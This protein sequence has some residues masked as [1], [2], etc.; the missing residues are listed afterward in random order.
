MYSKFL[1]LSSRNERKS[2]YTRWVNKET[3]LTLLH[4]FPLVTVF[5]RQ[6]NYSVV[7]HSYPHLHIN[8]GPPISIFVRNATLFVTLTPTFTFWQFISVYHN[9]HEICLNK[10]ITLPEI[11]IVSVSN[12]YVNDHI[13]CSKYHPSGDTKAS[14]HLWK[15]LTPWTMC[16]YGQAVQIQCSASFNSTTVLGFCCILCK[17]LALPALQNMTI[18]QTEVRQIWRPFISSFIKSLQFDLCQLWVT[19][20]V[21]GDVSNGPPVN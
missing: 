18:L 3:P 4:I 6:K 9:N 12:S 13:I 17:L 20:A 10:L 7:C 19:Y 14:S 1:Q 5:C 2:H 11:I 8:F 16:F 21:W 15:S